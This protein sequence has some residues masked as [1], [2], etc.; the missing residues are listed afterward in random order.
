MAFFPRESKQRAKKIFTANQNL[1]PG[2]ESLFSSKC[3]VYCQLLWGFYEE[4]S[5]GRLFNLA[6]HEEN[7]FSTTK[8]GN[9]FY[10]TVLTSC[11]LSRKKYCFAAYRTCKCWDINNLL[12]FSQT[13][14]IAEHVPWANEKETYT[15]RIYRVT[16]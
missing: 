1:H 3:F 16:I 8:E 14:K 10:S 2:C 9:R 11:L 13:I 6:I 12:L 7:F 4:T 5:W 15:T